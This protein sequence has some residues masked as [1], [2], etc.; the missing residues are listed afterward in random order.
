[1]TVASCA[2]TSCPDS[3]T[4]D[5]LGCA[6]ASVDSDCAESSMSPESAESCSAERCPVRDCE[7]RGQPDCASEKNA[8]TAT[9]AANTVRWFA[10]AVVS[11]AACYGTPAPAYRADES[12]FDSR[13]V[14]SGVSLA[15]SIYAATPPR[16]CRSTRCRIYE[17]DA[18]C[19]SATT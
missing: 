16:H 18:A 11:A 1:M 2:A 17:A 4:E 19:Y 12:A 9:S 10:A 13:P 15:R 14:A 3:S 8:V 7:R 6:E 5:C